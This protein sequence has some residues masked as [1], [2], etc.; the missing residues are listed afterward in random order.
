MCCCAAC[1]VALSMAGDDALGY[2]RGAG[3]SG[4]ACP[5]A[6]GD[7]E[8]AKVVTRNVRELAA[9][10]AML[11]NVAEAKELHDESMRHIAT[12]EGV[13]DDGELERMKNKAKDTLEKARGEYMKSLRQ[14]G[15]AAA[16]RAAGAGTSA[17]EPPVPSPA[18]GQREA[19][20]APA[21]SGKTRAPYGSRTSRSEASP[22][23]AKVKRERYNDNQEKILHQHF[24]SHEETGEKPDF[25]ALAA[26]VDGLHGGRPVSK[27][28]VMVWFKNFNS[29][30]RRR[31]SDLAGGVAKGAP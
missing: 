2:E 8:V 9:G 27:T 26:L 18:P 31:V 15:G 29:R 12:L 28:D 17:R 22:Q 25:G 1:V 7:P 10:V 23:G 21:G 14:G 6:K 20:A 11:R 19:A 16:A 5:P 3:A 24:K 30:K 4:G 13:L